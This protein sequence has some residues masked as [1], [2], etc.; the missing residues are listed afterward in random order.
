MCTHPG[1]ALYSP[2]WYS[3][4]RE[5]LQNLEMA[6]G[7]RGN[8]ADKGRYVQRSPT[9]HTERTMRGADR[10]AHYVRHKAAKTPANTEQAA[11]HLRTP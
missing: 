6:R 5:G 10:A 9:Y 3:N 11:S 1:T 2:V 7:G 8:R 4:F